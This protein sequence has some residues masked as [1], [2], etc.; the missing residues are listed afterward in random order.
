MRAL[1]FETLLADRWLSPIIVTFFNP[2]DPA[3]DFTAFYDAMKA[4]GYIIYPGKLTE[5]DSFR[6][7][8]IGQLDEE[9]MRGVVTAADRA[10]QQMG[11]KSAL[12][13]QAALEE[14]AKLAG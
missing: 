6:V 10:L 13:P 3:F 1:G 8:C 14:R 9:V 11:V 4:Q 2:A 12:P 5:V 7:G